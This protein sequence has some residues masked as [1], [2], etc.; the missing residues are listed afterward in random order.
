[1]AQTVT[2][3][4]ALIIKAQSDEATQ[5]LHEYEETIK[6]ATE[7]MSGAGEAADAHQRRP[8]CIRSAHARHE[9]RRISQPL[10]RTGP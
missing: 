4:L 3:E 2:E 10:A 5:A 8:D 1:M 7:A 9:R 6:K